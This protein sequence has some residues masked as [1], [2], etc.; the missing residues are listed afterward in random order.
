MWN[1][2]GGT[3]YAGS[4]STAS[5]G[6]IVVDEVK[7]FDVNLVKLTN[8]AGQQEPLCEMAFGGLFDSTTGDCKLP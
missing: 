7:V 3:Y 4:S 5:T 2:T 1:A 8:L 6:D